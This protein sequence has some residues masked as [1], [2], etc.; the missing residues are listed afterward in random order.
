MAKVNFWVSSTLPVDW[1]FIA[2]AGQIAGRALS[3]APEQNIRD[4]RDIRDIRG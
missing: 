4:I 1:A 2:G 3:G